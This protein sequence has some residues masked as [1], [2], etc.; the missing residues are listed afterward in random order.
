M[1]ASDYYENFVLKDGLKESMNSFNKLSESHE[2]IF[3]GGAGSPAEINLQTYDITNMKL[4]K[5]IL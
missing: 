5:K 1:H 3:L 4:P 2:I